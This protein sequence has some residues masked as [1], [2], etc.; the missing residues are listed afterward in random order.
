MNP[1]PSYFLVNRQI[2]LFVGLHEAEQE[3]DR[4][5]T[6]EELERVVDSLYED[7]E[8][9]WQRNVLIRE[10]ILKAVGKGVVNNGN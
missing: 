1:H 4:K 5:L 2:F 9:F 8:I 10:A 6:E 3:I 7:D